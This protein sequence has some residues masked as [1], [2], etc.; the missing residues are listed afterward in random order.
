M[1]RCKRCIMPETVPGITFNKEGVCSFCLNYQ[2]KTYFDKKELDRIIALS[3]N[4]NNKYDCIVPLSGGRDSSYVLYMAKRVYNC[5]VL[6]VS[7]DNEFRTDQPLV[8]MK[9]ACEILNVD[10]VDVRSKRAIAQ[11]RVKYNI[12]SAV[13]FGKFGICAACTYGIRSVVYRAAEEYKVPLI[14]WGHSQQEATQEM[15]REAFGALRLKR[16]K[17]LKLLNINFYKAEYCWLLQRLEFPVPGN[18]ILFRTRP[19][20]KNQDTKEIFVFDYI[21]WDRKKIKETIMTELGW[22]KPMGHKTTW[23]TDCMLHSFMNYC[24]FKLFGCSKNCFGYCNMINSGQM[25]REEALKQEEEMAATFTENIRE[26]LEGKIG[27]SK[28]LVAKIESFP[29]KM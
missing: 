19:F 10:F 12:R 16:P 28:K 27:L 2:K 4:K 17:I 1:R 24:F 25:D 29:T 13:A 8:N 14:L 7:Y 23:H 3:K 22:E 26:L 18:N 11:K 20:L 15:E 9:R 5:K 21:P 6:A